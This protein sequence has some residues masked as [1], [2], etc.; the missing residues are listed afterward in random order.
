MSAFWA[1]DPGGI[2]RRDARRVPAAIVSILALL[3]GAPAGA[4]PALHDSAQAIRRV[5][6]SDDGVQIDGATGVQSLGQGDSSRPRHGILIG[7]GR[8]RRV[9]ISPGGVHVGDLDRDVRVSGPIISVDDD[10]DDIVRIFADAEVPPGRRVDGDVVA[11]FGSVTVHGEVRGSTVA[12]FGNVVLDSTARVDDD[13]VAVGGSVENAPGSVVNG[14]TVSLGFLPIAWGLPAVP[15][16][17]GSIL[18][19]WLVS[20]F[21]GWLLQLLFADRM[22]RVA[23]T[24]SRRTA[25]SLL[26]GLI[27]APLLVI[28]CVLLVITVLGIPVALLLPVA[29]ALMTWA[30]HLAAAYVLGSKILRRP[31]SQPWTF[32]PLAVGTMFLAAFFV[33]GSVL[34]SGS[35]VV[36]TAALFFDLLGALL[37]FGLT[38]IGTGA[39]VL[40]RLGEQPAD[41]VAHPVAPAMSAQS[42]A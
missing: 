3:L 2:A 42:A 15:V 38:V 10:G 28:A 29:Y 22:M 41:V 23:V 26:I 19:L 17:I 37:W 39:F 14:Q 9:D 12:V 40:S 36:R 8:H 33:A 32:S 6:I 20:L 30:G 11:V 5:V 18:A 16:M 1:S 4:A 24:V 13:A 35:G 27:S 31:L 25:M 21:M 7:P 34:A